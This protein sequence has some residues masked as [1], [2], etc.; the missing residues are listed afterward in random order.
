MTVSESLTSKVKELASKYNDEALT[1][2]TDALCMA[3]LE[4]IKL[5]LAM[6]RFIH[7][8]IKEREAE[9]LGEA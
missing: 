3:Y 5:S 6:E 2:A 1:I 7:E 9:L 8:K 4:S